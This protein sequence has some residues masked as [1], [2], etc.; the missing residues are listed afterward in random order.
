VR[1]ASGLRDP[2]ARGR[3]TAEALAHLADLEARGRR[4]DFGSTK[5][6]RTLLRRA[7]RG[8]AIVA[9]PL[10]AGDHVKRALIHEGPWLVAA[11]AAFFLVKG[12]LVEVFVIPSESM[13]PTLV[14]GDRVVVF[15]P[16][17]GKVPERWSIVT[18]RL[19][20]DVWVKRLV[21]LPGER[22]AI[23]DGDVYASGR[24]LR[25]PDDLC[26]A[27]RRSYATWTLETPPDGWKSE[28]VAAGTEWS[29][30][31]TRRFYAHLA[32]GE[33][34]A[35]RDQRLTEIHDLYL[36]LEAERGADGTVALVLAREGAS[37]DE[38]RV[39][40]SLEV[41]PRGVALLEAPRP[42]A[43][44]STRTLAERAGAVPAGPVVLSL[45]YVDGVL[46]ASAGE[47]SWTGERPATEGAARPG[48]VFGGPDT[49]LKRLSMDQ[50]L[51]YSYPTDAIHGVPNRN[52]PWN[53]AS[54]AFAVPE[55]RVFLLGDNTTN[56]QDSR[57]ASPGA[58]PVEDLVG[59]ALFRVWPPGRI[60]GVR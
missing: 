36:D 28:E 24:L 34:L 47:W 57:F 29:P 6:A 13:V 11:V 59:P 44:G 16:A 56:S 18:F 33:A 38:A 30:E 53:V 40:W 4:R 46:R 42:W 58:I 48:V 17:G 12:F 60:G 25:K 54:Y 35:T 39:E 14:L 45:S 37:R 51:H 49:R 27:M 1:V 3:A 8:G 19:G 15:K 43:D 55:D 5:S 22:I 52:G 7:E 41:G 31:P 20:R 23:K 26:E 50:D 10:G 21:G 2:A 32:P 9:F